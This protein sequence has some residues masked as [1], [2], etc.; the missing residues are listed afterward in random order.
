MDGRHSVFADCECGMVT[1][2]CIAERFR[3]EVRT[4][5]GTLLMQEIDEQLGG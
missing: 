3:F 1:C 2:V 4:P 5:V